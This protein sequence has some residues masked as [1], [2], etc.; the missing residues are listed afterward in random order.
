MNSLPPA[1]QIRITF[2]PLKLPI[3]KTRGHLIARPFLRGRFGD[4]E[5]LP[6]DIYDFLETIRFTGQGLPVLKMSFGVI[7]DW[8]GGV[9]PDCGES[10]IITAG[11]GVL[12]CDDY[13]HPSC[14][15]NH[16]FSDDDHVYACLYGNCFLD[17]RP[18]KNQDLVLFSF[19]H[20]PGI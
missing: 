3:R 20:K 2:R 19:F 9:V 1:L 17:K 10:C 7:G 5:Y 14:F 15:C 11:G 18:S 16:S 13:T 8:P 12:D 6:S 4:R